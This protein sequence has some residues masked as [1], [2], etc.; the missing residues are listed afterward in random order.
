MLGSGIAMWQ[1]CCT[2]RCR[3]VVS[4]FVGGVVQHVRSRCRVVEFG[5]KD[6]CQP[7]KFNEKN[8]MKHGATKAGNLDLRNE[9]MHAVYT[10]VLSIYVKLRSYSKIVSLLMLLI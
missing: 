9:F 5:T 2:T 3:I 6:S 7:I 8:S 10:S 4:L 1:I